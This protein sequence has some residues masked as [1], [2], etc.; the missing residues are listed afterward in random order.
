LT[1]LPKR[2]EEIR[3]KWMYKAKKKNIDREVERHKAQLYCK[4]LQAKAWS[5]L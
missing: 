1:T 5:R 2:N 3:V 4:R